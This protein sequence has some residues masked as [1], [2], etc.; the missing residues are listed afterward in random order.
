VDPATLNAKVR[1]E[2]AVT[3][4]AAG[5]TQQPD[6][7]QIRA[8]VVAAGFASDEVEITEGRTP[9]GLAADAVEIAVRLG[10]N[11]IIAQ[12]RGGSVAAGVLPALA[13]G[14]CLIGT[15]GTR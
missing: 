2:A 3:G 5:G 10:R 11:C 7:A 6:T 9:T 15:V 13:G 4:A 12:L 1:L 14:G 8:A